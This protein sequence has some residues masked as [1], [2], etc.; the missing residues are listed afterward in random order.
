MAKGPPKQR[1]RSD[2]TQKVLDPALIHRLVYPRYTMLR[3]KKQWLPYGMPFKDLQKVDEY[4]ESVARF[5]REYILVTPDELVSWGLISYENP[6]RKQGEPKALSSKR[7]DYLEK[8]ESRLE[9][10]L[11]HCVVGDSKYR[12]YIFTTN[13]TMNVYRVDDE[14]QED[15]IQLSTKLRV[16]DWRNRKEVRDAQGRL[17]YEYPTIITQTTKLNMYIDIETPYYY[18]RS[19]RTYER[20]PYER[21]YRNMKGQTTTYTSYYRGGVKD[22]RWYFAQEEKPRQTKSAQ[23]KHETWAE[24]ASGQ[25]DV[26][27]LARQPFGGWVPRNRMLILVPRSFLNRIN[28]GVINHPFHIADIYPHKPSYDWEES[29]GE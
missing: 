5:A 1:L 22:S 24:R 17:T 11:P 8:Y 3:K 28:Y 21:Q 2:Y 18:A 7:P 10:V 13:P 12:S 27:F 16:R 20:V 9:E 4:E 14:A 26:R 6:K 25:Q 29:D 15:P 19:K 23:R